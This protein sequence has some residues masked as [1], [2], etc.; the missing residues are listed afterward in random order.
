MNKTKIYF[1]DSIVTIICLWAAY[2]IHTHTFINADVAWHVEGAKRL[3]LGGSYLENTFDNNS[4]F[5]FAYFFPLYWLKKIVFL[6]NTKLIVSYILFT[7]IIPLILCYQIINTTFKKEAAFAKR[8]LYYSIVFILLFLPAF[9]TGHREVVLINF[10]L[11]YFLILV[12]SAT[13]QK[14]HQVNQFICYVAAILASFAI[15]QNIFYLS[16]PI[17]I[18]VYRY[19]KTK[20]FQSFQ[21]LF[22][23]CILFDAALVTVLYPE[24]IKYII[25]MVLRYESGFNFSLLILLLE[26]LTFINL[27]TILIVLLN[28]KNLHKSNEIIMCLIAASCSLLIYFFEMKLWYYHLYPALAFNILI[29]S[30]LIITYYEESILKSRVACRINLLSASIA[31][32]LLATI[33][34]TILGFLRAEYHLFY[35]PTYKMNRWIQYA[36]MNFENSKLLFLVIPL[37]PAYFPPLYS[38][39]NIKLVSPWSNPWM[40]PYIILYNQDKKDSF[41]FQRDTQIFKK[42]ASQSIYKMKPDYIIV[43]TT[44]KQLLAEGKQFDYISFFSANKN[45]LKNFQGYSFYGTFDDYTI[46]KKLTPSFTK[47]IS[48]TYF[49]G[50]THSDMK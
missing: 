7:I 27:L 45:F 21:L 25:P 44:P 8:M 43:E 5:V 17:S 42:L 13:H 20:R 38:N 41:G 33:I 40:L 30:L 50:S 36:K 6:P 16:L 47:H 24:Y 35:D 29:L 48:D 37:S 46:Y 26:V 9:N 49:T 32:G 31:C 12:F 2:W 19:L 10:Y 1:L 3:L 18:D 23:I 34:A 14:S 28:L 39:V 22:Y 15:A 4:P 11:P